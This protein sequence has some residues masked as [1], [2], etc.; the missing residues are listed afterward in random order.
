MVWTDPGSLSTAS[1]ARTHRGGNTP[2]PATTLGITERN[3]LGVVT[4]LT[5]AA[6][7]VNDTEAA[8]RGHRIHGNAA[9]QSDQQ[10]E[11]GV[12]L[13]P[14]AEGGGEPV[15]RNA[16]DPW[17]AGLEGQ[18]GRA[19]NPPRWRESAGP[20]AP[21][22]PEHRGVNVVPGPLPA[23]QPV[24]GAELSGQRD[25]AVQRHPAHDLGVHEILLGSA[26]LPDALVLAGPAARGRIGDGDQEGLGGGSS[27]PIWSRSRPTAASSSP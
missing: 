13:L 21:A 17:Q 1:V 2:R 8:S 22:V 20:L 19:R 4:G 18:Q 27:S 23:L 9:G 14:A 26:D 6:D 11:C 7:A 12:A 24:L 5:T 3:V 25:G 15:P 16:H 10:H